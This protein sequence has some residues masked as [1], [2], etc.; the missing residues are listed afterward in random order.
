MIYNNKTILSLLTTLG[1]GSMLLVASCNSDEFLEDNGTNT[2][3]FTEPRN[4]E[5]FETIIE[6]AYY[7]MSGE[8]GFRGMLNA[9]VLFSAFTSDEGWLPDEYINVSDD[10]RQWYNR[11]FTD[12]T[13]S[14]PERTWSAAYATIGATNLIIDFL[15]GDPANGFDDRN[16]EAWTPRVLGEAYFLRAFS[17]YQLAR[18]FGPPPT[19][20][21]SAPSIILRA[22]TPEGAFDNP[23]LAS[24]QEVYDLIV[25]DLNRAMEL[26]PEAFVEGRD[27]LAY[28]DRATRWAAVF[29]AAE[30]NFM[31]NNFE[32]AEQYATEV[33][34]SGRFE[35][36]EDILDAWD[37]NSLGAQAPEVIWQYV[38][39]NRNQQR[40]KP[41]IIHRY[42]GFTDANGNPDRVSTEQRLS[43]S[44]V[45][46]ENLGW[47]NPDVAA[48]D[49]RHN[50]LY[51]RIEAGEDSRPN[52]DQI[53]GLRIWPNKWYRA[54][55]SGWGT[56]ST[57]SLPLMRLPE[58]Y[59]TR[60]TV[61]LLNGNSQGAADDLNAVKRRAWAGDASA[62]VPVSASEITEEMIALE[63]MIE[64]AF[65]DDRI[66]YLQ[67]MQMDIPPGERIAT[68]PFPYGQV[69]LPIPQTEADINPNVE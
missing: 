1:I 50:E 38:G 56:A 69:E 7:S 35:L 6:G 11:D 52:Y 26:L 43:L 59:L 23:G 64:L 60:A 34:E 9:P 55:F 15:Q 4:S 54:E 36:Q 61:R 47:N 8:G 12:R 30:V 66:Y 31:L 41:I 37:D 46:V 62:F 65:E 49:K 16:G 63:R 33:I 2:F 21:P 53:P 13:L 10:A 58:M 18:M 17:H 32:L 22:K 39:Y 29:M 3:G 44:D 67:A 25:S 68:S 45:L 5:D 40:W 24:V 42:L 27:P 51:V 14:Q 19:A 28:E 48:L 57:A 20:D